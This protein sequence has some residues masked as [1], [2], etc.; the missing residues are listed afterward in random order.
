MTT[1]ID[2]GILLLVYAGLSV[3]CT[4]LLRVLRALPRRTVHEGVAALGW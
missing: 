4:A 1:L 3:F 2:T